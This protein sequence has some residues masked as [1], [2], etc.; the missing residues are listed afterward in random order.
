MHAGEM[1]TCQVA[2]TLTTHES[3][4][5]LWR[6]FG[7]MACCFLA[8]LVL[9]PPHYNDNFQTCQTWRVG[10][11]MLARCARVKSHAHSPRTSRD[12]PCGVC[13]GVWRVV[14]WPSWCLVH[15]TTMTT[16]KRARRGEW[17]YA[18]WR[19]VHVSSRTHSHHT[20][21]EMHLV[22]CVWE[23]G[24]LCFGPV[25]AW[26]TTLPWHLSNV[27]DVASGRMH[28]GE[29]CTCQVAR[30]LTTHESRCTLW[31]VFGSM[32]CCFLAKLVLGPPHYHDTIQTCQTWRV[33]VCMLA[34]CARAKSHAHSPH[35]SR[36]APCGVCLGVWRV[37]FWPSWCSVHHTTMT[38]FKRA[39]RGEWAYA[40]WRDV[41]VPSRTHTH[42]TRVEMHLVACVWEYGVLCFGQVGAWSTTLP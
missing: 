8:K 17:A 42:H 11:C 22:A 20:R 37:V 9:G 16:F 32:A 28:A 10:V 35:T 26:S 2:R 29:M 18:C 1:C 19:D 13:L 5:T 6:V 7:S 12:A 31:R 4:C 36:D 14:F 33:G 15:H 39:R 34:R 27:P 30:T 25:G 40:C 38:P 24:V 41:H 23:Y 3:R 21:V